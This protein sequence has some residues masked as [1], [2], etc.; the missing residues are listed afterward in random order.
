MNTT[1]NQTLDIHGTHFNYAQATCKIALSAACIGLGI[2]LWPLREHAFWPEWDSPLWVTWNSPEAKSLA[3][4]I[5]V[6]PLIIAAILTKGIVGDSD[7]PK[8]PAVF[9]PP[10]CRFASLSRMA[11]VNTRVGRYPAVSPRHTP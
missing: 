6:M 8:T 10:G 2:F 4:L 3:R 7:G 11:E 5:A 9:L 1:T